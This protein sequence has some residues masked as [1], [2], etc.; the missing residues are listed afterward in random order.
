[1]TINGTVQSSSLM[2]IAFTN[3]HLSNWIAQ[4]TSLLQG[5][6]SNSVIIKPLSKES[7]H[8][9]KLSRNAKKWYL[10]RR[11]NYRNTDKTITTCPFFKYNTHQLRPKK[12]K[13]ILCLAL[14]YHQNN[15]NT[16]LTGFK[17]IYL[18]E[19]RV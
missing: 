19:Y 7:K 13:K 8:K 16:S 2:S 18:V 9:M 14:F 6:I 11:H 4:Q 3:K 5:V 12:K 17:N 15:L 10:L 1:M